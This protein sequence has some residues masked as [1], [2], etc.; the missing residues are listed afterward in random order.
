MTN[1][2]RTFGQRLREAR[3]AHG[4]TQQEL[5]HPLCTHAYISTL[6]ADKRVP[7]QRVLSHLASKLQMDVGDLL[8]EEEADLE[9]LALKQVAPA[10]RMNRRS[11]RGCPETG[12]PV[13][14]R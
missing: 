7:S 10:L 12:E 2:H 8:L 13:R 6:E 9:I 4:L 3:I 5:A 11:R 14:R 1:E